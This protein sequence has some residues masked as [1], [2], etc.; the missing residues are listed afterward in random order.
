[1]AIS[2][3]LTLRIRKALY[4]LCKLGFI[5]VTFFYLNKKLEIMKNEDSLTHIN[6][7]D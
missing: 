5:G 4:Y 3:S 2:G 6:M 1:M 7:T